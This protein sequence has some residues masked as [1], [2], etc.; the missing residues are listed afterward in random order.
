MPGGTLHIGYSKATVPIHEPS[1]LGP[2]LVP[3][4][5]GPHETKGRNVQ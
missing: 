3:Q 4:R 2:N 1:T 5:A